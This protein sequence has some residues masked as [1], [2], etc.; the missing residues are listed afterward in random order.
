MM[1]GFCLFSTTSIQITIGL[2]ILITKAKKSPKISVYPNML[3][4][5]ALAELSETAP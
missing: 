4:I 3:S 1:S 2:T 5:L